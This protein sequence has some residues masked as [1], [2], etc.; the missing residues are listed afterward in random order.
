LSELG[1]IASRA[2]RAA[3]QIL[4]TDPTQQFRLSEALHHSLEHAIR[5]GQIEPVTQPIVGYLRTALESCTA[6]DVA[7]VSRT[8]ANEWADAARR[9]ALLTELI[10]APELKLEPTYVGPSFSLGKI[11]T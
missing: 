3:Q 2:T 4:V 1:A 5:L 6:R 9:A 8:Y 11:R 7:S 10:A